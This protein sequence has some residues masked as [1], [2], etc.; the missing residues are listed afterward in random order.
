MPKVGG[1]HYSYTPKGIAK[2]KAQAKK[3]GVKVQYKAKGGNVIRGKEVG[4]QDPFFRKDSLIRSKDSDLQNVDADAE[5]E[6]GLRIHR[7]PGMKTGGAVKKK[8][9]SAGIAKAGFGIEI[10]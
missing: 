6:L 5:R 1:T 10:K 7:G 8:R 3:K 9:K 4:L 2:A